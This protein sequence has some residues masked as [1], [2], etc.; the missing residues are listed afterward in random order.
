[1]RWKAESIYVICARCARKNANSTPLHQSR[2]ILRSLQITSDVFFFR[3]EFWSAR[4]KEKSVENELSG[5]LPEA[6]QKLSKETK[7]NLETDKRFNV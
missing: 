3:K 7:R 5:R 6:Q 2:G 4:Y 1:M